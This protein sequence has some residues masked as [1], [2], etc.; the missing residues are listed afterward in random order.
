MFKKVIFGEVAKTEDGRVLGKEVGG[1]PGRIF[2]EDANGK[3]I[4]AAY[5]TTDE[6]GIFHTFCTGT[7]CGKNC[8]HSDAPSCRYN[9]KYVDNA[10][11]YVNLD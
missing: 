8:F 3:M 4:G 1:F 7:T 9:R 2:F 10:G 5:G 11:Y 6:F